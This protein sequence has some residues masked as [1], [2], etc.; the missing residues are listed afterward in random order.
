VQWM[1]AAAQPKQKRS[2][3]QKPKGKP[4]PKPKQKGSGSVEARP[5]TQAE[6]QVQ[7]ISADKFPEGSLAMTTMG[8]CKIT[9]LT[10]RMGITKMTFPE[11]NEPSGHCPSSPQTVLT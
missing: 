8:V 11:G 3:P 4:G 5:Q 7:I 9:R 1:E 10:M 2:Q 6:P